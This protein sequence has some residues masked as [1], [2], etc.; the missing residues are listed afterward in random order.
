[1]KR[2]T[3]FL[4]MAFLQK[5]NLKAQ[6]QIQYY[7]PVNFSEVQVTDHFWKP[8]MDLV[9]AK[10]LRACIYQTEIATPR[11]RNFINGAHHTGKSIGIDYDDSDVYKAPEAMGYS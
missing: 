9:A 7:T 2:L 8:K 11:I 6:Q 3:A 1:M 5:A 10:S 4:I